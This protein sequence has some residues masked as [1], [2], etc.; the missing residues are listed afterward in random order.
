MCKFTHMLQFVLGLFC[1]FHY[2]RPWNNWVREQRWSENMGGE[3]GEED[4]LEGRVLK[5]RRAE[6]SCAGGKSVALIYIS[7]LEHCKTMSGDNSVR[8]LNSRAPIQRNKNT[9]GCCLFLSLACYNDMCGCFEH[10]S[11]MCPPLLSAS[12]ERLWVWLSSWR[13]VDGQ[14][15]KSVEQQ[16]RQDILRDVIHVVLF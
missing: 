2:A 9:R 11:C 10:L 15:V 4:E 14:S 8:E 1:H 12:F 5:G 13:S 16:S 3:G 7:L 6:R